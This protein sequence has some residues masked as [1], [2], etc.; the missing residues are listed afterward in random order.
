MSEPDKAG[1]LFIFF[2][3][4]LSTSGAGILPVLSAVP[5]KAGDGGLSAKVRRPKTQK[6]GA[7][8]PGDIG[9]EEN[10][11]GGPVRNRTG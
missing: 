6:Q 10:K 2:V 9:S 5:E 4:N 3:H 8:Q 7:G 11:R 1:T